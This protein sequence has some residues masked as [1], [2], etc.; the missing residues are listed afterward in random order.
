MKPDSQ[1]F[2]FTLALSTLAC[3]CIPAKTSSSS[4]AKSKN[5]MEGQNPSDNLGSSIKNITNGPADTCPA[6]TSGESEYCQI[7]HQKAGEANSAID[8]LWVIENSGNIMHMPATVANNFETF[9]NKFSNQA[10][11]TDFKMA[12]I[13][14]DSQKPAANRDSEGKLT[15][16]ELKKNRKNFI[17]HFVDKVTFKPGET[18]VQDEES[19]LAKSLEFLQTRPPWARPNAYLIIIYVTDEDDHSCPTG[20]PSW[21]GGAGECPT[22]GFSET[23]SVAQKVVDYYF[24]PIIKMKNDNSNLIKVFAIVNQPGNTFPSYLSV[25]VRYNK[26]VQTFGGKSYNIINSFDGILR[27][28][29]QKVADLASLFPLKYPAQEGSI[30]VTINGASVPQG[31]WQYLSGDRAIRFEKNALPRAGS[32]I[33][34]VYQTQ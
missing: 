15:S 20:Y 29:G 7:F 11:N 28:F 18:V 33:K 16:A 14:T 26:A 21:T 30:E 12:V 8:I 17:N 13:S 31:D 32:T 9:I 5:T 24:N 1:I 27:D 22:Q 25:G 34:V 10:L 3:G 23:E 4:K 6:S 2:L 19:G